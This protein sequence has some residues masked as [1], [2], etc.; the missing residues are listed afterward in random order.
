ML[1]EAKD[2]YPST[3][4]AIQARASKIG[5]TSDTLRSWHKKYIDQTILAVNTPF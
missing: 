5:C 4:A 3:W 1:I 2:G